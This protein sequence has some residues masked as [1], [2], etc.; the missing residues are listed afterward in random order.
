MPESATQLSPQNERMLLDVQTCCQFTFLRK[1]EALTSGVLA[2][3]FMRISNRSLVEIGF[4]DLHA[5]RHVFDTWSSASEDSDDLFNNNLEKLVPRTRS[6][7]RRGSSCRASSEPRFRRV[8]SSES[9]STSCASS[10]DVS[11][12]SEIDTS[13][14]SEGYITSPRCDETSQ[15]AAS[16][17]GSAPLRE[18][19]PEPFREHIQVPAHPS[20]GSLGH[21]FCC[22]FPCKYAF[23]GKGCKEGANCKRCHLCRWSRQSELLWKQ[24]QMLEQASSSQS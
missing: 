21:P 13:I 11:E 14:D 8:G 10:E 2:I 4:S 22:S 9:V 7:H 5:A 6:F 19:S 1:Q 23:K 20:L 16:P 12:H 18:E 15:H 24:K 17:S 3:V